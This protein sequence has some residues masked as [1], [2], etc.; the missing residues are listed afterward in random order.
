MDN[1]DLNLDN[2]ELE[3][4]LKLFKLNYDFTESDIKQAK[5]IVLKV[6]PDKSGLSKEYFLFFAKAYKMLYSIHVFRNKD[7]NQSVAYI[8]HND[9]NKKEVFSKFTES[10]EFN[11][12]FNKLFEKHN[13]DSEYSITGYGNWLKSEEDIDD[14]C[15]TLNEIH[16]TFERKKTKA[17]E[18]VKVNE[19]V[20]LEN[21]GG[22]DLIGDAPESYGSNI[23]S[24]LQYEDLQRAHKETIIPVCSKDYEAIPKYKSQEELVRH[25]SGNTFEPLSKKNAIDILSSE[26]KKSDVS[27]VTRAFKLA[28]HDEAVKQANDRWFGFFNKLSYS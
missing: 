26:K 8:A 11:D 22:N 12:Q 2:Y 15:T 5:R 17:R 7:K 21:S 28:K 10:N 6:H 23:F 16:S 3:D 1:I 27:D 14:S 4:L 20:G 13:I 24:K 9:E 18:L 25:R 19:I